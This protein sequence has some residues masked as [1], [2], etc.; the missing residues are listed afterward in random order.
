[1]RQFISMEDAFSEVERVARDHA[2]TTASRTLS[3]AVGAVLAEPCVAQLSIPP[4]DNSARDG[5][6][7]SESGLEMARAGEPIPVRG[8]LAAGSTLD[9][10]D[11]IEEPC[12]RIMTGAPVPRWGV[13]IVMLED[14]DFDGHTVTLKTLPARGDWIRVA[15]SDIEKGR[16]ILNAGRRLIAEHVQ[17]LAS[18]GVATVTVNQTPRVGVCSTGEE[19]VDLTDGELSSGQI[20][21]SNRPSLGAMLES[22]GCYLDVSEH[23]GDSLEAM[24]DFL[25]RAMAR[26]LNVLVSSGA[27]SMGQYDFV[28]PA[29]EAI[30]AE[31]IFH[32]VTQKPG[33][34]LLFAVLP[35]GTLY[36]GL[37][38]N[39]VS[40]TVNCRF[41]VQAAVAA[42]QGQPRQHPLKLP[43]ATPIDTPHGL[44]VFL[45]ARCE[46]ATSGVIVRAL[47]GQESFQTEPLLQMN[48]WIQLD[49]S[50]GSVPAGDLV[51][52]FPAHPDGLPDIF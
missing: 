19:L 32:K 41:Y 20:Y 21:D 25:N 52:F 22:Y 5:F 6:V 9:A 46:P 11:A 34:P 35:N 23:V 16:Q 1:M 42:M 12:A 30:G 47:E 2:V 17:A 10:A 43:A 7:V 4:F 26:D 18:A 29:L 51:S 38:G 33:K 37:P 50:V 31:I 40:S 13:A 15:G 36:F 48:G 24:V 45:K 14:V 8:E 28:K 44:A 39:P 3:E 27:V 49:E